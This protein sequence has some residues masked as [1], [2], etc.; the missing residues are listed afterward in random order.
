VAAS[1]EQMNTG[2]QFT[3]LAVNTSLIEASGPLI[4]TVAK[5]RYAW[6]QAEALGSWSKSAN[7]AASAFQ[8]MMVSLAKNSDKTDAGNLAANQAA[9]NFLGAFVKPLGMDDQTYKK[10]LMGFYRAAAE[11]GNGYALTALKGAGVLNLLT[12]EERVRLEDVELKY[13]NRA[14]GRAA[15]QF[16]EDLDRLNFNMTFGKVSSTEAMAQLTQINEEIKSRT[17]FD[18][19]LFDYK[20]VT[21]VGKSV[22][23]ALKANLDKQEARKWQ[24]EDRAAQQSFQ[25]QLKEKEASDEAAA[26]QLAYATG[27]IKTATAAGIGSSGNYDLLAQADFAAKDFTRIIRAYNND[28]WVSGLVRDNIQA[29]ISSSIG[30]EYNKDFEQ[31]AQTF[32][33]LNKTKPAVA[34][35]YYGDLYTPMA[36]YQRLIGSGR[37]SPT[38]AFQQAFSNPAQYAGTPELDQK[39]AKKV[40][41]WIDGNRGGSW[42]GL[43]RSGLNTSGKQALTNAMA[44][45]IG[46]LSKN[47]DL[48][49]DALVPNLY[50]D[51]V[52]SGAYEDYGKLGWTNKVGTTNLG[53]M[54]NLQQ[55]EAD[56]VVTAVVDRELRRTG[57]ADG[58]DGD[59]YDVRRIRDSKGNVVLAVTPYDEDTGA[60]TTALIPFSMFKQQADTLRAGRV[61]TVKPGRA[62]SGVNPYR[63][64]PGET[65]AQRVARINREVAAGA[66]PVKH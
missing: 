64:V 46:V 9:N 59:N 55:D 10:G 60:A 32:A 36:N 5:E 35:A 66:D 18:V 6:Q 15:L 3:D 2:D 25:L 8:G 49:I 1:F 65:G 7:S 54:L 13:G 45:Q 34:M 38:Q 61:A 56:E 24:L 26:V 43:G 22:W 14:Q 41:D 58:A 20:E 27:R 40:A 63:R 33:A 11:A 39:G 28:Q 17:G 12:D 62:Y 48:P 30:Q 51:L 57:F 21:G 37:L 50:T 23:T 53:K 16:G 44:R 29:Q 47:S 4:G 42:F 31:G 52:R 19:D